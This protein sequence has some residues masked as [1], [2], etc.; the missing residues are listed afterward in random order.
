MHYTDRNSRD[1]IKKVISSKNVRLAR[2]IVRHGPFNPPWQ[3]IY[4]DIITFNVAMKNDGCLL[5]L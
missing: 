2:F 3:I 5:R 4:H 1:T